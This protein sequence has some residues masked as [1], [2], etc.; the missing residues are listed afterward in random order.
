GRAAWLRA[1]PDLRLET[2][3]HEVGF[4]KG[5]PAEAF[6]PAASVPA[7]LTGADRKALL[8]AIEGLGDGLLRR[9]SFA[10]RSLSAAEAAI[11]R[12]GSA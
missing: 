11:L 6:P 12:H 10:R 7:A 8:G 5:L 3:R 1:G 2:D 4:A 9:G